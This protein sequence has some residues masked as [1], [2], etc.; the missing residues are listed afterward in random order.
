MLN[1]KVVEPQLSGFTVLGLAKLSVYGNFKDKNPLKIGEDI[2]QV[3]STGTDSF[4]LS[5]ET[6]NIVT[7]LWNLHDS[8]DAFDFSNLKKHPDI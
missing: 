2:E 3:H 8:F 5:F 4:V 6:D 7:D 1:K